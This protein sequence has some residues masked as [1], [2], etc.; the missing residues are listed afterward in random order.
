MHANRREFQ[1]GLTN[2]AAARLT[3]AL[4]GALG[5]ALRACSPFAFIGV[6]SRFN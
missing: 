3:P 5:R 2:T 1:R 4:G 6:H